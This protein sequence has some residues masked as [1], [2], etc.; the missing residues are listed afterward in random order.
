MEA[1]AAGLP[2]REAWEI[3]LQVSIE[4]HRILEVQAV[5]TGSQY[6]HILRVFSKS[7]NIAR[8]TSHFGNLKNRL[9]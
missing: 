1:I 3:M 4:M 5:I 8:W 2:L 6:S 7:Q 9:L